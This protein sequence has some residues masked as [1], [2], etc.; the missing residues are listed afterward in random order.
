MTPSTWALLILWTY[1]ANMHSVS[2]ENPAPHF[3]PLIEPFSDHPYKVIESCK[4]PHQSI[5]LSALL[6]RSYS[7]GFLSINRPIDS[8]LINF[9]G[10]PFRPRELQ[11][12]VISP[13]GAGSC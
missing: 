6:D 10:I 11:F 13:I 12:L 3:R 4:Q 1:F 7:A 8:V 9:Y 2:Q 5:D